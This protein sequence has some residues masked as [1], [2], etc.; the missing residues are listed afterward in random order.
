MISELYKITPSD[1]GVSVIMPGLVDSKTGD[2][3]GTTKIKY[4]SRIEAKKAILRSQKRVLEHA[5]L[6]DLKNYNGAYLRIEAILHEGHIEYHVTVPDIIPFADGRGGG[7]PH[8]RVIKYTTWDAAKKTLLSCLQRS[9]NLE[10][11]KLLAITLPSE[12]TFRF[13]NFVDFDPQ[14]T[15]SSGTRALSNIVEKYLGYKGENTLDKSQYTYKQTIKNENWRTDLYSFLSDYLD[16]EGADILTDLNIE[17]LD[18]LTP[19]QAISLSSRIVLELTAYNE[20]DDSEAGNKK[21]D[22]SK[23][24]QSTALDILKEGRENKTNEKWQGNGVCRN[25]ACSL[26]AV[27]ECLKS[28]QI[29]FS[30]LNDTYCHYSSDIASNASRSNSF[31]PKREQFNALSLSAPIGH[32]WNTFFTIAENGKIDVSIIDVTWVAR[33][34]DA[35]KQTGNLDHTAT[36]I[37]PII[38]TVAQDMTPDFDLYAEQISKIASYYADRLKKLNE[39]T[40][41][42]SV[43]EQG[44]LLTDALAFGGQQP[45][46]FAFPE[47]YVSTVLESAVRI[48][49]ELMIEE[50]EALH[51]ICE[52]SEAYQLDFN[53]V[54]TGFLK[55][56]RMSDRRNYMLSRDDKLQE[57]IFDILKNRKDFDVKIKDQPALYRRLM[58]IDPTLFV[59]FDP[60]ASQQDSKVFS[61]MIERSNGLR[62]YSSLAM[63]SGN[64]TQRPNNIQKITQTARRALEEI[65]AQVYKKSIASV[66]DYYLIANFDSL[67][68][69]LEEPV[70]QDVPLRRSLKSIPTFR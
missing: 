49:P 11:E 17:R 16:N 30:R 31:M 61:H 70:G 47:S 65:D 67:K 39:K 21:N 4:P 34:H 46:F 63:S 12:E 40:D 36:R 68:K 60:V 57:L 22:R 20:A 42:F 26:K 54:L 35:I 23:A 51:H 62:R 66:N 32:A 50:I 14:V 29:N 41:R 10:A 33:N 58:D 25:F 24:D 45:D 27:F 2:F 6:R 37:L 64:R 43:N 38:K 13:F 53:G 8:K 48:A 3:C 1:G 15:P 52:S 55:D 56:K 69:A 19:K 7:I 28:A 59:D 5:E 18:M 44:A 9:K